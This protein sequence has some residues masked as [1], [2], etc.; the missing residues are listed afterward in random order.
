MLL[1]TSVATHTII[2]SGKMNDRSRPGNSIS[3]TTADTGPCVVAPNT[4]PAPSN[5]NKPAGTPG[6]TWDHANPIAA[7]SSAP[8]VR[9][10]V[11]MP[12][13]APLRMQKTVAIGFSNNKIR[14][15]AGATCPLNA[16][17]DTSL[18]FPRICGNQIDATPSAPITP[19]GHANRCQPFGLFWSAHVIARMYPTDAIPA[20]GAA[21]SAHIIK[22]AEFTNAGISYVGWFGRKIYATPVAINAVINA[23]ST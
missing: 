20:I 17:C 11:N 18:P 15:R 16:S 6:H 2:S 3:N 1:D 23:G 22:D 19:T 10:G 12:P 13:G 14:S 5:A 21:T 4:A 8:N 9:D 7:P